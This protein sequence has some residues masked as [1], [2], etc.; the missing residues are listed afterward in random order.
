MKWSYVVLTDGDDWPC[1]VLFVSWVNSLLTDGMERPCDT[2]GPTDGTC[3]KWDISQNEIYEQF[4]KYNTQYPPFIIF[5]KGKCR[6][7]YNPKCVLC[8]KFQQLNATG[9]KWPWASP[10][11]HWINTPKNCQEKSHKNA[12]KLSYSYLSLPKTQM[13][14]WIRCQTQ[15][16]SNVVKITHY[17][18]GLY[19][20][21]L[22]PSL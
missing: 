17:T 22:Q 7:H 2:K 16:V 6:K 14:T 13:S 12:T 10:I 21:S 15:Q 3:L 20:G 4:W 8:G 18:L 9:T 1:Y 5:L 11:N 19:R